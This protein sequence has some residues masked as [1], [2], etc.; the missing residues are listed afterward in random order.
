MQYGR[1]EPNRSLHVCDLWRR[2]Q[3]KD[4]SAFARCITCA[5]RH[6]LTLQP[7]LVKQRTAPS[8]QGQPGQRREPKLQRMA[9]G[10]IDDGGPSHLTRSFPFSA[11]SGGII[12][13]PLSIERRTWKLGRG[14]DKSQSSLVCVGKPR[15]EERRFLSSSQIRRLC[16]ETGLL[17]H[18][19]AQFHVEMAALVRALVQHE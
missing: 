1:L 17:V 6:L 5:E 7:Q 10:R 18:L 2:L 13:I 16:P 3:G 8:R 15:L 12:D 19:P 4:V 14:H 9:R 11:S